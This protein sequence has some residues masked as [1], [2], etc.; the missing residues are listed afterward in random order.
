[1]TVE[2]LCNAVMGCNPAIGK[3][4]IPVILLTLFVVIIVGTIQLRRKQ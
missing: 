3:W 2:Q 1:M 4:A